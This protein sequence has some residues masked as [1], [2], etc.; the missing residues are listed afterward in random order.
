MSRSDL[1]FLFLLFLL[2]LI[3]AYA[4]CPVAIDDYSTPASTLL[5]NRFA[6]FMNRVDTCLHVVSSSFIVLMEVIKRQYALWSFDSDH[7]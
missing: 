3:K 7:R 4:N 5:L 1:L 2:N 6:S